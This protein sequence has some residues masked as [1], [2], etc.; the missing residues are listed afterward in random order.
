MWI[1]GSKNDKLS[2]IIAD[3]GREMTI[4]FTIIFLLY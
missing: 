3:N 2:M 1:G 4:S